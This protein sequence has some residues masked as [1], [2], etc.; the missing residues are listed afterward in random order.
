[1]NMN[2]NTNDVIFEMNRRMIG[3]LLI[4]IGGLL[5]WIGGLLILIG[6]L[7]ILIGG[8]RQIEELKHI[9]QTAKYKMIPYYLTELI[10]VST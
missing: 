3:G 5:I 8:L 9:Y 4:W 7:L 2:T 1:M 6:G 10:I